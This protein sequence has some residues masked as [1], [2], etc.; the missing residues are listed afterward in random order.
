MPLSVMMFLH[1]EK[2]KMVC[3]F[4]TSV[5][6]HMCLVLDRRLTVLLNLATHI[7]MD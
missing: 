5:C 1:G 7:I 4:F 3:N 2:A 6:K